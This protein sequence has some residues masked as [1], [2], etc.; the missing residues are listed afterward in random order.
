MFTIIM[1]PNFF[2]CD[3]SSQQ[4]FLTDLRLPKVRAR[5]VKLLTPLVKCQKLART[6]G[7]H[8]QE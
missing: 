5:K 6:V 8:L 1:Q 3:I 4:K 7:A 2:H